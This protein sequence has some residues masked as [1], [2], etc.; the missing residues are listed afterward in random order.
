MNH[1]DDSIGTFSSVKGLINQKI[2]L[3][4]DCSTTNTKDATFPWCQE[5]N[6]AWLQWTIWIVNLWENNVR[7]YMYM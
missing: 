5:I 3:L 4:W 1:T 6:W 2:D 7:L